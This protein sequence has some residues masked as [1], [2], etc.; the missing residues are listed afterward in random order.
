[1]SALALHHHPDGWEIRRYGAAAIAIVALHAA[2]I[3]AASFSYQRSEPAGFS[4][5]AILIDLPPAPAAPQIQTETDG[6]G[7]VTQEAEAPPP[8]LPKT[9]MIEQL[10][11]T[12]VQEKPVVAAPPKVEPK[13][14]P[15]PAKPQPIKDVKKPIRKQ[16]AEAARAS[17]AER[18][19]QEAPAISSGASAAATAAAYR[20]LLVAHLLRFKA[21]PAGAE[22]RGENGKALVT[23]TVTRNGRVSGAKLTRSTG[24]A[25]L[26]QEALAWIQRAQPMPAFP[27]DMREATMNF[28]AP[29]NWERR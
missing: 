21:W 5:P 16:L 3:T 15:A 26:D 2:L 27:A 6:V 14:E 13:P 7:P 28:T 4:G 20:A 1:M 12:P 23:F 25:S 22:A 9:E 19:A 8:E 29:L 18:I 24:Y 11:P 17:K 10:L